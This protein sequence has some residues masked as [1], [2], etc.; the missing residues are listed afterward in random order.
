MDW[1]DILYVLSEEGGVKD[2]NNF[3]GSPVMNRLQECPV[4]MGA[5]RLEHFG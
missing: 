5:A 1:T 2:A 3:C 4:K